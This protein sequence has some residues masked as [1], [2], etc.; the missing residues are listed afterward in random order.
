M[1]IWVHFPDLIL[2]GNISNFAPVWS[3]D[4]HIIILSVYLLIEC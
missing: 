3:K 2:Y 1:E 4:E